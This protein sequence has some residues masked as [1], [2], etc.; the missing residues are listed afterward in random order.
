MTRHRLRAVLVA[1]AVAALAAGCG[2]GGDDGADLPA[3][4]PRQVPTAQSGSPRGQAPAPGAAAPTAPPGTP[5]AAAPPAPVPAPGE[6]TPASPPAGAPSR[7][8]APAPVTVPAPGDPVPDGPAPLDPDPPERPSA[9]SGSPAPRP[10]PPARAPGAAHHPIVGVEDDR[11]VNPEAVPAARVAMIA[12]T[13][14]RM[15]RVAV[16]WKDVA[17]RRPA[18]PA[19]PDDPAYRFGRTDAIV[20]ALAARGVTPL[21]VV[22]NAPA[23]A[24]G[25]ATTVTAAMPYNA[26]PP[27]PARFGEFMRAVSTRYSGGHRAGGATLPRVRYWELWNEPN[28]S[29]FLHPQGSSAQW[30]AAY[31]ALAKAG[32]PAVKAGGG[33]DT[34]VMAGATGPRGATGRGAIGVRDWIAGLRANGV[35]MDAYSQHIYPA[36]GPLESTTAMP[37]WSSL[38]EIYALLDAWR[39][40]LPVYITEAGY[41]TAPTPYRKVAVSE[42]AQARYVRDIFTLRAVRDPRLKAVIWFNLQD[43]PNWP[44]GLLRA[45]GR[46][47]PSMA[48]YRRVAAA[49]R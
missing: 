39:P 42:S 41:T 24:S 35:P 2:G 49:A 12:S 21:L 37:S 26:V 22:Y 4:A 10:A 48:V 7:A 38:P 20:K 45:D 28:L 34:V 5:S 32:Y 36:A 15:A 13:R 16:F 25:N 43:N 40:G 29:L 44:A 14:A 8:P 19:D 9:P 17:P 1:S 46:P 33:D 27:D 18:S 23:W 3:D 31:A 6:P 30:A 11:L 47:K